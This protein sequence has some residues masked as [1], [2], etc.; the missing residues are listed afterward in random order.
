MKQFGAKG[1]GISDDTQAITKALNSNIQTI[2]AEK[3]KAYYKVSNLIVVNMIAKKNFIVKDANIL[4]SDLTKATFL[5]Q[6]SKNIEIQGGKFGYIITPVKNGGNSQ[7]VFQFDK[8]Q[9]VL[10]N[11]VH[12]TNSPEMGIAITN[13]NNVVIQNSRIEHTFRDG[14]YS[15]YSANVKY[16]NN[17]YSNIKDDAMSFH[18]YGIMA[19]KKKLLSYGY[20]QATDLL[21]QG[22]YV[23]NAYQG[24]GSIGANNVK[25]VNN[26]IKNTVIAGIAVFNSL[27]LYPKGT[28]LVKNVKIL[29]NSIDN[30]CITVSIN[31][32]EYQNFGQAS[33]GRAGIFVGSL[34]I[35]NQINASETKRLR[36]ILIEG[37]KVTNS[38]AHGFVGTYIDNLKF[39][40]NKFTNC[41]GSVPQK[42][43]TGDV[44]EMGNITDLFGNKNSVID[45]RNQVMHQHAYSL[46]NVAGKMGNWNVKG[47]LASESKLSE[48]RSLSILPNEV[49]R[50]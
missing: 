46:V 44:I 31:G 1:D 5:F 30:P 12:I 8:C 42:S 39:I 19:D 43:L 17:V 6:N 11:K 26:R 14:T 37:N 15:H 50:K 34:G 35:N 21:A 38:G 47:V 32:T 9:N 48:T 45:N 33:T 25:V 7:H 49:Q 41:S 24:F 22:N 18:D 2:Y 10:V 29:N 36:D 23:E 40:N 20:S 3:T 28:A 27:E 16:L 13:S 4:N